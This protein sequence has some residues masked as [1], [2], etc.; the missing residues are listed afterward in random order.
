MVMLTEY[1]E[2][3]AKYTAVTPVGKRGYVVSRLVFP[4]A[5]SFLYSLLLMFFFTLSVWPAA[6]LLAACALSCLFSMI[7]CLLVVAFSHNRVEG[8][9]IYKLSGMILLGLFIPFFLRS[10]VQYLFSFLPSF[11]LGKLCLEEG[12]WTVIPALLSAA[13]W[14][15]PLYGKFEAKFS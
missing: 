15:W 3:I 5:I 14:L 13:L 6:L 8:L 10:G 1:D 9:A 4:A 11:W 2:S 12:V 7:V